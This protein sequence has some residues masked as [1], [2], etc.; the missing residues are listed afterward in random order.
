MCKVFGRLLVQF[1]AKGHQLVQREDK[2]L[3]FAGKNDLKIALAK[4]AH[5]LAANTA[6]GA[7][8]VCIEP[9]LT[10]DDGNGD[11]IT[12]TVVNGRKECHALGANGGGLQ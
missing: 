9:A 4:F 2:R 3:L 5:H 6:R 1:K 11:K 10:A 7:C 8:L 12:V